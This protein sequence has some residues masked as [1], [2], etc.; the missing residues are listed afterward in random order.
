MTSYAYMEA[1]W[2][3]IGHSVSNAFEELG[4]GFCKTTP[5]KGH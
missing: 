2:Q 1:D 3:P 4:G 5:C